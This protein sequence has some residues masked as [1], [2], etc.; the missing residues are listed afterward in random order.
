MGHSAQVFIIIILLNMSLEYQTQVSPQ[1]YQASFVP[2]S[3]F[4]DPVYRIFFHISTYSSE[5]PIDTPLNVYFK[6]NRDLENVLIP[7]T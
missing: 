6:K 3:Y 2:T 5:R 7:D 1:D 4:P